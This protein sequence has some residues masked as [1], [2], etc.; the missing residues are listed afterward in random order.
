MN[1]MCETCRHWGPYCHQCPVG[2]CTDPD[3]LLHPCVV[4]KDTCGNWKPDV[5]V[6]QEKG[7]NHGK[8]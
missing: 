3:N 8:Q 4:H 7:E 2:W 1:H 6:T 5:V